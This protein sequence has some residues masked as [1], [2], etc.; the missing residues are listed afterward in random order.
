MSALSDTRSVLEFAD[1]NAR[2]AATKRV[3]PRSQGSAS[4][5]GYRADWGN[6]ISRTMAALVEGRDYALAS[7]SEG[8]SALKSVVRVKLTD[9][10][11]R[12]I[13]DFHKNK[14]SN[15]GSSAAIRFKGGYGEIQIPDQQQNKRS[16]QF[17]LSGIQG[18]PNGSFECLQQHASPRASPA[19]A[20]LGD[21]SHNLA[22]H[23]TD[24]VYKTTR[25]RMTQAEQESKK[26]CAQEIKPR[27]PRHSSHVIK[28]K[29]PP[30]PPPKRPSALDVAPSRAHSMA[31]RNT[32][33]PS[34][35]S[36][37]LQ[38]V[39]SPT[40][41]PVQRTTNPEV[42]ARPL[43]ERV[44]HL[45]AIRPFKKPELI[46]RLQKDGIRDRDRNSL[47][48]ILKTVALF[49]P[50]DNSYSLLRHL[51][52]E[53]KED[54]PFYTETDRQLLKRRKADG[55]PAQLSPAH[56]PAA[57]AAAAAASLTASASPAAPP[58]QHAPPQKRSPSAMA[59]SSDYSQPPIKRQRIAH[60]SA[61]KT[62]PKTDPH[63]PK[64]TASKQPKTSSV[65]NS[66]GGGGLA[67]SKEKL[68]LDSPNSLGES[69]ENNNYLGDA[70]PDK[71]APD[72][73]RQY[74]NIRSGDQRQKYKK[75]FNA[76]Y[77]EY[78]QL[79]AKIDRVSNKFRT[80]VEKI[81]REEKGSAGYENMKSHIFMEYQTV[82][83]NPKYLEQRKR[84]DYLYK[85]LGHIKKQIT[86]F[87]LLTPVLS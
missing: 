55:S 28:R 27:G 81:Q 5:P 58:P 9:S 44:V 21:I 57:P 18:D 50:R 12:A 82:K 16:F 17:S 35:P 24:D 30:P 36:K 25:E 1:H 59:P 7:S 11:L 52:S 8:A 72:F 19:L 33:S 65:S 66:N 85:K 23:A 14:R 64:V 37:P 71:D 70:S 84:C 56:S 3:L 69:Q 86:E 6:A 47:F 10:A 2:G 78:R 68:K 63:A 83:N 60:H 51:L 53:V 75:D 38:A 26:S 20:S 76:E 77:E 31:P 13:E 62:D 54:W 32:H 79:H 45:L 22:I 67:F 4:E 80:L 34:A 48:P 42:M 43:K 49:N 61:P 40:A 41:A 74:P 73:V 15:S 46:A 87:D 39:P 29:V